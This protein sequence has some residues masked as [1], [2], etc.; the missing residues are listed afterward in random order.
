MLYEP[1]RERDK[2][3]EEKKVQKIRFIFTD[4][5][6][7]LANN[8]AT[9]FLRD[10]AITLIAALKMLCWGGSLGECALLRESPNWETPME[11]IFSG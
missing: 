1:A 6:W 2:Q 8:F 3:K 4:V 9:I 7:F 5:I 10:L 11:I